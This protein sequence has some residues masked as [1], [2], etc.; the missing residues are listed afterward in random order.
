MA[1]WGKTHDVAIAKSVRQGRRTSTPIY[2]TAFGSAYCGDSL[3]VLR[4]RPLGTLKG[5]I[6]LAFT[7]PPFPLNTK[8]SYGNLQGD[9]YVRWFARFAPL[10]RDMVTKDGSIV[11]EI[12]N[13]WVPG[14]PTMST[15]VLE[16]FLRFL[17]MGDLHLC[18]EFIWYNPARLPSPIE[19][20]NKERMRV[21]DAFTRIWWMSPSPRPKA[22][23]RKVLREYSS[24][25]KRLIKTGRYNAGARPSEH[26]IG[27]ESFKT[28]NNGA[29][30]PNVGGV[31]ALPSLD[32]VITPKGFAEFLEE[33]TNLLKASN[34]LSNDEYR[35]FCLNRGSPVHPARMP[36]SLVE[37]FVKFLTDK[38]DTVLDPFAGSNT[39]GAVAQDLGR[40]WISIEADWNY[41][42]HSIG[43][44]SP[45]ALTSISEGF[46]ITEIEKAAE[47]ADG[48][49][50]DYSGT[51]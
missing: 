29:I 7:S 14:Q 9:E 21:K 34:T 28:N 32:A 38:G 3:K 10:L 47:L 26:H 50:P 48:G 19:W 25:M 11:I 44:F 45:A 20:V 42:A 15:H 22:D 4:S 23:N 1:T 30:P 33:T 24:S 39:T 17:K 43:R 41:A 8:K 31:D 46:E 12:G 18:Q 6:Q 36:P 40:R 35:R 27:A 5:K 51:A 49:V 16:A 37:F 2:T 13:A